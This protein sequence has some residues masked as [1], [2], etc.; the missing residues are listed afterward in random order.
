VRP[1]GF[2][3][4]RT[5]RKGPSNREDHCAR[6]KARRRKHTEPERAEVVFWLLHVAA[7]LFGFVLLFVT[8]P[9]HLFYR[10]KYRKTDV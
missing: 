6:P 5:A 10:A 8:I 7:F 1:H 9:A 3:Y 2:T 4:D